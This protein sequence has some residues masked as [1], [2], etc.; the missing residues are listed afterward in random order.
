MIFFSGTSATL[1]HYG[2]ENV[3]LNTVYDDSGNG[4]NALLVHGAHK[5]KGEAKCGASVQLSG[6]EIYIE[7][8]NMKDKP[9]EAVTVAM[10]VKLDSEEDNLSIFNIDQAVDGSGATYALEIKNGKLHWGHSDENGN[11]LFDLLTVQKSTMPKGLWSH[12]AATYDSHKGQARL[13]IDAQL[14]KSEPGGGTL[15]TVWKGKT[16]IGKNG[17]LP[18]HVDEF[19]FLKRSLTISDIKDLTELCNL[20][21][22]YSIPM[23][24]DAYT[25]ILTNDQIQAAKNRYKEDKNIHIT[26]H[27]DHDDPINLVPDHCSRNAVLYN[28]DISGGKAAGIFVDAGETSGIDACIQNCCKTPRCNLAYLEKKRCY[29]VICHF[30][31]LCQPV[32]AGKALVTLGYISRN[33]KN[34]YRPGISIDV[35]LYMIFVL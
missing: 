34:V 31:S 17:K 5:S 18:G 19:Y 28:T 9:V 16:F 33:G 15:S 29:T 22:E 1:I 25:G 11:V 26:T 30:P 4:N 2:F 8:Q 13:F 24:K 20:D 14:I 10:W 7:G 35:I 23:D 12:I 32:K 3:N 21:A 6:G 27:L